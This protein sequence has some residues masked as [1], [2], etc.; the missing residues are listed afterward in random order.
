VGSG[1]VRRMSRR[2]DISPEP[3]SSGSSAGRG[4]TG[5]RRVARARAAAAEVANSGGA[6]IT[7][8]Y[9]GV[10]PGSIDD[11][12][13]AVE[14]GSARPKTTEATT[15]TAAELSVLRQLP[16]HLSLAQIADKQVVSRNTVKLKSHRSIESSASTTARKRSIGHQRKD[17][18]TRR[19]PS[20]TGRHTS[21]R[22]TPHPAREPVGTG[23]GRHRSRSAQEPV[24]T[25]VGTRA[26]MSH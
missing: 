15:P 24:G 25:R 2:A 7:L 18:S 26:L 22:R 10:L 3:T 16:T 17:F 20:T 8:P 1:S 6:A 11:L 23:A 13:A 21:A 12:A 4:P 9:A 19:P 14:D 5:C